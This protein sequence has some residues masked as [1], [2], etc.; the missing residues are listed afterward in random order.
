MATL[1]EFLAEWHSP[2]PYVQAHTSGS[3]GTPKPIRLLKADMQLSARATNSFFGIGEHSVLASPLS[4]G[5]IAGKM[6]AVRA[7]E[8]HCALVPL[9]VSNRIELPDTLPHVDL[10]PIVPSQ[11]ESLLAQPAY[12]ARISHVLVGGAAPSPAQFRALTDAGYKAYISFGMTETCSHVALARADDTTRTFHAMPGISFSTD[13]RGCLA[14]EAPHF[15]FGRLQTNDVVQLIDSTSFRWRGRADGVINSGGIKLFPEELESLYAPVLGGRP[16]YVCG[17]AH[18][19]WGQAAILVLEGD[20]DTAA[21]ASALRA[22]IAD[23]H[24]L[25]KEIIAVPSLPRTENGKIRRI[26]PR[27]P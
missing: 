24:R 23:T 16:F 19:V 22:A 12:A 21:I 1:S 10:L 26:D 7:I 20:A 25:P 17:T 3:T 15:S 13:S 8:A 6:M 9:P 5:Y 4:F 14:I 18:P 11:I 27:K 2:D